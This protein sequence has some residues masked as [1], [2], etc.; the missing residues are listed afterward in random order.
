MRA[1]PS[2]A[3]P[4]PNE[5]AAAKKQDVQL[6][7]HLEVTS[8]AQ[9]VGPM[10]PPQA[11]TGCEGATTPGYAGPLY[12]GPYRVDLPGMH[13]PAPQWAPPGIMRPWPTDEYIFDGGDRDL[14]VEVNPDYSVRG[15]DQEDT[16]VHYDTVDGETLVKPSNRVCIYAPRFSSVRKVYGV[17]IQEQHERMFEVDKPTGIV[18]QELRLPPGAGCSR[19]SRSARTA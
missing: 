11:W 15:L 3:L 2:P 13:G 16:V 19:S 10:L 8:G 7:E 4:S 18:S 6:V 5:A 17:D 12:Q 14:A 9:P 1:A